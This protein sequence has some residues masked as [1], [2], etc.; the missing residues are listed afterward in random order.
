MSITC[1]RVGLGKRGTIVES[2]EL[3]WRS[4]L[5][6]FSFPGTDEARED[7]KSQRWT[8]MSDDDRRNTEPEFVFL[9][10]EKQGERENLRESETFGE[11]IGIDSDED[12]ERRVRDELRASITATKKKIQL[13]LSVFFFF[14]RC[15]SIVR[16]Q[17]LRLISVC[18]SFWA[19]IAIGPKYGP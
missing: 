15:S 9:L 13:V 4:E 5:A 1:E 10:L 19:C 11:N 16:Y 7:K 2:L 18:V 14:V 12:D 6:S 8:G 17:K 3:D